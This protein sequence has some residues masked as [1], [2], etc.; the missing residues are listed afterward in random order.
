MRLRDVLL[1]PL[2][3]SP[4]RRALAFVDACAANFTSIGG[5]RDV[6]SDFSP[7]ELKEYLAATEYF[8]MYLSCSPGEKSY[9]SD[10]LKHG[11]WTHFLLQALRGEAQEALDS[12]R[13]LTDQT[14]KNYLRTAV[15]Q[16]MTRE[17]T[18]RGAQ[19]P[20]ALIR[21][22]GTFAI[23]HVPLPVVL[24][25]EA[26]D[27][28][29]VRIK[30]TREFF[31]GIEEGEI[32]NLP[33]F[34]KHKHFAP[35]RPNLDATTSF[36]KQLLA[37]T[38]QE[39][40]QKLYEHV[41][42]AMKLR[43]REIEH[44]S[45]NGFGS[46]DTEYF[47][48]TVEPRHHMKEASMYQI[49][50]TLELRTAA[51]DNRIAQIDEIFSSTFDKLVVKT[52]RDFIDFATLVDKLEDIEAANGGTVRDEPAHE[53]VTYTAPDGATIVF[54]VAAGKISM[55]TRGAN[56]I[57]ALLTTAQGYR[58]GLEGQSRLLLS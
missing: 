8:A 22:S 44:E 32:K 53:R 13:H 14:L 26:G 29:D 20:E 16:Y 2:Q 25:S 30:P 37:D 19:T 58:F 6:I 24:V 49:V 21:A 11:I 40:T 54:S 46:I 39:E 52:N 15:R 45:E 3:A 31:Q 48:Y 33:G 36:I 7:D 47:R 43:S 10:R 17:T 35:D 5:A 56:S 28:R 27:L 34:V 23:R 41:K 12:E 9:P 4:C 50:K 1:D 55:S 18:H 51:D 38:I 57:R 42:Q